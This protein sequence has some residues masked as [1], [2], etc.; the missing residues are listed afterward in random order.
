MLSDLFFRYGFNQFYNDEI[1]SY[2]A[3]RILLIQG[4][5]LDSSFIIPN[6]KGKSSI[7]VLFGSDVY[8]PSTITH[9]KELY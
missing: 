2:N 6:E 3:L 7:M 9:G 5:P 1:N 4:D 8:D